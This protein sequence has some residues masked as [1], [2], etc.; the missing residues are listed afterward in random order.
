MT[1]INCTVQISPL[2]GDEVKTLFTNLRIKNSHKKKIKGLK[3]SGESTNE[4]TQ[5]SDQR[6]VFQAKSFC[7]WTT[8]IGMVSKIARNPHQ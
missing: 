4:V 3:V 2:T 6:Q 1:Y 5:L 7:G 8:A